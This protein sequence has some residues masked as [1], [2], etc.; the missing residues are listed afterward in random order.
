MSTKDRGTFLCHTEGGPSFRLPLVTPQDP[1]PQVHATRGRRRPLLPGPCDTR[2]DAH[3]DASGGN[4]AASP[5]PT[6]PR[7]KDGPYPN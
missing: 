3:V 4:K 5:P 6:G 1:S 2:R 7:A